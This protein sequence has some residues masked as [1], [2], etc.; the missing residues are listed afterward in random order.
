VLQKYLFW[1]VG[2]PVQ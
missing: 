2:L 1:S